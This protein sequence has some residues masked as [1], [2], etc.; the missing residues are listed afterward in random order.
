MAVTFDP[1]RTQAA[2]VSLFARALVPGL[3][4]AVLACGGAADPAS[5]GGGDGSTAGS[6]TAHDADGSSGVHGTVGDASGS[7]GDAPG[8]EGSDTASPQPDVGGV[9]PGTVPVF[10]AQGSMGR[11]VMS[12][13]GGL[14]W[15]SDHAWDL[16]GNALVC[17]GPQAKRCWDDT[18]SYAQDG[19][20]VDTE[21]CNDTPDEAKGVA[22]GD[23]IFAAT[24]G[25]GMP[26]AL[27]SSTDGA[28]WSFAPGDTHGGIAYGLGRFVAASR[29]PVWS[30]DGVTWQPTEPADFQNE[31]GADLWSV[32]SFAYGDYQDG[33]RFVAVATGDGRDILVSSDG[34]SWWRPSEIPTECGTDTFFYGSILGGN[35]VF[36]IVGQPGTACRSIDG[37]Q[38]W[39]MV[40]TG[41]SEILSHGVWTG[42]QFEYWGDDGVRASSSDGLDWTL[43]PMTTPMRIGPVARDDE[44]NYVA[45]DSVWSAYEAQTFLHSDDGLSW[46]AAPG[47][48]AGH[49]IF[50]IVAGRIAATQA[51]PAR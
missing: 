18:C 6:T 14:T 51:C 25:W 30:A 46:S 34:Q 31:G 17:G 15:I 5:D 23:G 22:F 39:S 43:T 20:C 48:A 19:G 21:C 27:G 33:G 35:D 9:E 40:D 4:G 44:G 1:A 3:A 36:V 2:L 29:D 13:D 50:H 24:W 49:P 28:T 7:S 41:L 8:S 26:G 42:T 16:D 38:T 12:C 11:T 10:V 47:S 37:G 45:I 32:R